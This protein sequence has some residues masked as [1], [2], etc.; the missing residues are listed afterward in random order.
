MSCPVI[1]IANQKGGVGKTT[2]AINLSA[3]LAAQ[4]VPTLL[5]DLDP[6]GNT[7]S[8]L[9]MTREEGV[10]LYAPIL[11]E[12][13]A[14]SMVQE[15]RVPSLSLIPSELDL[16][17]VETQL[18]GMKNYLTK[19]RK[20]LAPLKKSR[21]FK[22]IIL[23]CPPA[24]GMLC[25]NGL[26]AAAYLLIALQCEY[27]A[28][29]GLGQILRVMEQIK[30]SGANK[31]LK[32]GGILMTMFHGRT[33]ISE[34]V[35]SEVRRHFKKDIFKS[36]IPRSVR[37][38]EAPSFGQTIFEY[39]GDSPGAWSYRNLGLEVIKRFGLK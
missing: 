12:G 34:Q 29:E 38:S 2:T 35:V 39:D 4:D 11:G 17:V 26:A 36:I 21:K 7:T 8:G 20:C 30:S 32:L 10:S 25:M 22:A 23:D 5:V 3:A 16:A 19:L 31:Q 37:L 27:L 18:G 33:K 6:Q 14:A 28:M 1:T 24:L 13:L 15:T 9:G